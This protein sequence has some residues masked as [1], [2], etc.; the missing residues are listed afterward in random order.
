MIVSRDVVGT[1]AE[2]DSGMRA[3]GVTGSGVGI[4]VVIWSREIVG[5]WS[6]DDVGREVGR[7]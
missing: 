2:T 3:G 5:I 7:G 4:G 6:R 1:V